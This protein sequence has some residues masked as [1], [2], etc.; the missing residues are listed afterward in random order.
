MLFMIISNSI[1]GGILGFCM[2]GL[3][4]NTTSYEFWIVV[5]FISIIILNG[6]K[7]G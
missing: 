5:A 6:N 1:I 2:Q 3:G 7:N 4:Y